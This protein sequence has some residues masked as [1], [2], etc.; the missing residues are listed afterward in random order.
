[1]E[2]KTK[3]ILDSNIL[4]AYFRK[5]ELNFKK[6]NII[7]SSLENFILT[8]H[9]LFEIGTILLLK[10]DKDIAQ[11]ALKFIVENEQISIFNL[12]DEEFNQTIDNFP[13]SNKKLSMVDLSLLI[14]AKNHN[15]ELISFD[16]ELM[17]AWKDFNKSDKNLMS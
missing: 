12:S 10:E 14:I 8:E 3:Y 15:L 9:C 11:K 13:Y 7:L 1:M 2:L 17:R 6:A 5:E 16:E 4:I